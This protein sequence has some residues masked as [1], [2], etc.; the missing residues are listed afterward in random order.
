[1]MR[2]R[3]VFVV[4][5]SCGALSGCQ[6]SFNESPK[7]STGNIGDNSQG[8]DGP[9]G[10]AGP[11]GPG[12]VW[13][14]ATGAAAE[15]VVANPA[16]GALLYVDAN[17]SIWKIDAETAALDVVESGIA[18]QWTNADCTG[19]A[20]VKAPLPRLTFRTL[21]DS[22]VRVRG[23]TTTTVAANVASTS[24]ADGGCDVLPQ[25]I[26]QAMILLPAASPLDAPALGLVAPLHPERP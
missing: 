16:S 1:M 10:P 5:L 3:F 26:A 12:I 20:Y 17:G 9:Q 18:V 14:D 7:L 15:G 11:P 24:R 13:K 23:D 22:G 6:N 19:S 2:G 4:V 21:G 8:K 25:P